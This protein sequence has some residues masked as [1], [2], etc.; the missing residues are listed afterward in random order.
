[1]NRNR[2]AEYLYGYSPGEALGQNAIELLTDVQDHPVARNIVHRV[3]TGERWI[4]QFPVK[5]KSGDR[6]LVVATNTPFYDDDGAMVG[7]I[8]VSTDSKPFQ[9]TKA[10]LS[11]LGHSEASPGF[12]RPKMM[13]SARLGLD[14][15][16]PLQVSIAS[17]ISNLV[18]SL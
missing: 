18:S 16:Q 17:K 10:S 7:V 13:A 12:S 1:M 14:P 5:N 4:G 3:T 2:T 11:G 9:E 8:C 15:Q 6:L